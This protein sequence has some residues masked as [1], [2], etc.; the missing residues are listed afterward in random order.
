MVLD[1]AIGSIMDKVDLCITG[2]EG[3]MENGG[4]INKVKIIGISR[5]KHIM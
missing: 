1:C 3:V 5:Y 2:A 4:I